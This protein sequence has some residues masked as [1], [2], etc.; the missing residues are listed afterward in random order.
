[1]ALKIIE[2][3]GVKGQKW[4]VRR[5]QNEDG[6]LTALGREHYGVSELSSIN[7]DLDSREANNYAVKQREKL[8]KKI[9]FAKQQEQKQIEKQAEDRYGKDYSNK[10]DKWIN[11]EVKKNLEGADAAKREVDDWLESILGEY[12]R[13]NINDEKEAERLTEK[14]KQDEEKAMKYMQKLRLKE[15]AEARK[16]ADRQMKADERAALA[17]AK[18]EEKAREDAQR[19]QDKADLKREKMFQREEEKAEIRQRKIDAKY[20]KEAAAQR[21]KKIIGGIAA[22]A[23]GAA[24]LG[25]VYKKLK[26][27]SGNPLD[28]D[29]DGDVDASDMK[30]MAGGAKTVGSAFDTNGDGKFDAKDAARVFARGRSA[31]PGATKP[32]IAGL[33]GYTP[34]HRTLDRTASLNKTEAADALRRMYA[35]EAFKK[36]RVTNFLNRPKTV[37]S[38]DLNRILDRYRRYPTTDYD[39]SSVLFPTKKHRLRILR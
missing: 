33:L 12:S 31:S 10:K 29:G 20:E 28:T 5:Y 11:A 25:G 26:G 39:L 2:H 21:R 6:S 18:R 22:T 3:S 32:N 34:N 7:R 38:G 15:I 24:I 36:Q 1:M 35:A 19:R 9:N 37:S 23:A 27:G 14:G 16:D 4:G 17:A 8:Y 13:L 30:R